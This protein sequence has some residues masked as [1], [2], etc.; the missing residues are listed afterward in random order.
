MTNEDLLIRAAK[1]AGYVYDPNAGKIFVTA[2]DGYPIKLDW[3][4]LENDDDAFRLS[5]ELLLSIHQADDHVKISWKDCR[6]PIGEV[7]LSCHHSFRS[8]ATRLAIV[9]AASNFYEEKELSKMIQDDMELEIIET[10]K[11]IATKQTLLVIKGLPFRCSCGCNVFT[12]VDGYTF[13]C[14]A[15]ET[16]YEGE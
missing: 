11:N 1:A 8:K 14:N 16:K 15:C 12:R 6:F 13:I 9:R 5:C 4:P 3:N 7:C 10:M 2:S